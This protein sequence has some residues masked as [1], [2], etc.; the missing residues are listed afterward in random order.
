M[1]GTSF[2]TETSVECDSRADARVFA[3]DSI[4]ANGL[5]G[6]GF[7]VD[8]EPEGNTRISCRGDYLECPPVDPI[9]EPFNRPWQCEKRKARAA[10]FLGWMIGAG[11]HRE[12]AFNILDTLY[13]DG[14]AEG[15]GW[16]W[17]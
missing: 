3:Y 6:A 12:D 14:A 2:E 10:Q 5:V 4:V 7:E 9:C 15:K 16:G 1:N 17:V 11:M 8:G 13:R